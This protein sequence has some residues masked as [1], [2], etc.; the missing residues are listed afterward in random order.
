VSCF[1]YREYTLLCDDPL[2]LAAYG[3]FGVERS[4]PELRRLAAREG[5]AHI[6][7]AAPGSHSGKDYCPEHRPPS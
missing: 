2:C 5:W 4:R 3:P 1:V 7:D 6:R